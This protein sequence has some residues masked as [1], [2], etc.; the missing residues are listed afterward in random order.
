MTTQTELFP[1]T[2][3]DDANAVLNKLLADREKAEK[4][5]ATAKEKLDAIDVLIRRQQGVIRHLGKRQ[6]LDDAVDAVRGMQRTA[7]EG[8]FSA[9]IEINGEKVVLSEGPEIHV[10]PETGEVVEPETPDPSFPA[11]VRVMRPDA[12]TPVITEVGEHTTY[13]ELVADYL[14]ENLI[15]LEVDDFAVVSEHGSA[16]PLDAV[17]VAPDYGRE[18]RICEREASAEPAA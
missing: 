11:T 9:S 10:E 15:D 4:A 16:R 1:K 12:T 13:G 6:P 3:I 17:I 18:F 2:E 7:E 8:G 14:A 5:V